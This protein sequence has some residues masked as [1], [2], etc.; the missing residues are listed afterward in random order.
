MRQRF[1][2]CVTLKI[3]IT[4]VLFAFAR[5]IRFLRFHYDI[6][7]RG[8]LHAFLFLKKWGKHWKE[9]DLGV[10]KARLLLY[11][12]GKRFTCEMEKV[13]KKWKPIRILRRFMMN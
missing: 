6:F 13:I 4:I 10:A 11:S 8:C 12:K 7:L 3:K 2:L 9:A 1:F 5:T